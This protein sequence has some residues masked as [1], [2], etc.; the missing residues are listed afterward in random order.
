MISAVFP[1]WSSCQ[2]V[3]RVS[4]FL[5][6]YPLLLSQSKTVSFPLSP[7]STRR[8]V[9]FSSDT[10][11]ASPVFSLPRSIATIFI[12]LDAASAGILYDVS[13]IRHIINIAV[14]CFQRLL[15]FILVPPIFLM[16]TYV[17]FIITLSADIASFL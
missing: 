9:P 12:L 6:L 7:L 11:V 13:V 3:T 17:Y 10:I 1:A 8:D 14:S 2:C 15:F 4:N 5:F 16:Y